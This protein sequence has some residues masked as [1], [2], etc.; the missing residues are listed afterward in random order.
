MY[1]S[2]RRLFQNPLTHKNSIASKIQ[3]GNL[4]GIEASAVSQE[5]HSLPAVSFCPDQSMP[6]WSVDR[7]HNSRDL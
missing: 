6:G 5:M 7:I 3:N 4:G 1:T 2:Y